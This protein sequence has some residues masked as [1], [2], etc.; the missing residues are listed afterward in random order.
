MTC[1][2]QRLPSLR[3]Q[4]TLLVFATTDILVME[5]ADLA[6]SKDAERWHAALAGYDKAIEGHSKT[7][8]RRSGLVKLDRDVRQTIPQNVESRRSEDAPNG[9]LTK[10]DICKI[11]EWKITVTFCAYYL[12]T[13]TKLRLRLPYLTERQ[14]P[15]STINRLNR[16]KIFMTSWAIFYSPLMRYA[17]VLN[18]EEVHGTSKEALELAAKD[19]S[20]VGRIGGRSPMLL[21][22]TRTFTGN[23]NSHKFE[24]NRSGNS[25]SHTVASRLPWQ[26]SFFIR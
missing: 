18:S 4:L 2:S 24:G 16:T 12:L 10:E 23:D 25:F 19:P 17:N 7:G 15:V 13:V 8:K 5:A 20:E 21:L 26:L 22:L 14:V 1:L 11:V 9:Y 6:K 3:A